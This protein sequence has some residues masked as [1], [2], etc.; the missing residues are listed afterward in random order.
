[1]TAPTVAPTPTAAT[2]PAIDTE[3]GADARWPG[4]A[5]A[6]VLLVVAV[7]GWLTGQVLTLVLFAPAAIA[8]LTL[9]HRV[10]AGVRR[11]LDFGPITSPLAP[12]SRPHLAQFVVR[13]ALGVLTLAAAR[14]ALLDIEAGGL[15]D[16]ST[17]RLLVAAPV[18]AFVALQ[19]VPSRN[20]SRSLN[21]VAV[22]AAGFLGFQLVKLAT[23]SGGEHV[24][25]IE[26]P[27]E[28][29][30]A[31]TWHVPSAGPSTLVSHHWTP[32]ADQL[33]AVD[34][35]V[36]RDGA[37]RDG[38]ASDLAAYHC[39]NEPI[40][41]PGDGVVVAAE[42][43]RPD[44]EIGSTDPD[45]AAGNVVV[46]DLG[47]DVFVQL[48]HLREG[49]VAVDVGDRVAQGDVIGRCGNSGHSL[50]PHL[51]LQVQDSPSTVNSHQ[52][53]THGGGEITTFPFHIAGTDSPDRPLR[54]NDRVI[55]EP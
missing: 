48:A 47:D 14:H 8:G 36:E 9:G 12:G 5:L 18:I 43:G 40:L 21:L 52:A 53:G 13:A 28:A 22:I 10:V 1:M 23:D 29:P 42:D 11:R 17:Q 6:V 51:H 19:L 25:T 45:H 16:P 20:V 38:D 15:P 54:R 34:F 46:I 2:A 24:V 44:V 39:W 7:A 41:A 35:V 33:W 32:L 30:T 3:K 31:G 26:A 4:R 49:T 37:T 55:V 50:E 27:F